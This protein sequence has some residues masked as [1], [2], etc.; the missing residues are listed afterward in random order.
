M[1]SIAKTLAVVSVA[2]TC[3]AGAQA[4]S[5]YAATKYPFVMAH[6]AAGFD[7]IGPIDYLSLIHI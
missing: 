1:T 7:K 3:A 5:T 4:A 2:M 6:G